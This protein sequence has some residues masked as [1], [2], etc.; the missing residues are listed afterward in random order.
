MEIRAAQQDLRCIL[1]SCIIGSFTMMLS[2]SAVDE[3]VEVA[4]NFKHFCS[5]TE[6]WSSCSTFWLIDL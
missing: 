5:E 3:M 2:D 1:L 4:N 6:V